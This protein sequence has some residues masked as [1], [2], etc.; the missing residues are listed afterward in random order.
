MLWFVAMTLLFGGTDALAGRRSAPAAAEATE[1]G[2]DARLTTYA[3]PHAV[4]VLPLRLQ[5]QDLELA[6]M[7]VVPDEPNGGTVLLLHGKNFSGAYWEPTIRV[8]TAAGYRVVVPDQIG[9]GKSSKPPHFQ[10]SFHALADATRTLLDHLKVEEV[11]VVGHS[12]GGML[13]TRFSLL[14]PERVRGLALL[15]P[16]GLEDWQE[17]VP[18]QS[19]DHWYAAELKKTPAGIRAYMQAS[20]FDGV[21]KP[22]YDPLVE[23]LAGWTLGPDHAR[24]AWSSALTYD[25]IFTQPVVHDF[26]RLTVP[27]LL[28]VGERDRTALGKGL[29][30]PEVAAT[31]G[32]YRALGEAVASAIPDCELVL[33][34]GIGHIPQLEAPEQ[35]HAALLGFVASSAPRHR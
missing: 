25:M 35:T 23:I 15:N 28:V 8:L 17:K 2:L 26:P 20:Y 3:Y 32:D 11:T 5:Q 6:Y 18:Y 22:A 29:V 34:P 14:Y 12:M 1:A 31:M 33:L 24:I 10:Y 27:T 4:A 30:A 9:F 19:V 7:D 16:I 13:A 21:W